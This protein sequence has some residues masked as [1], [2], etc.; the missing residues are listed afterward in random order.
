[1]YLKLFVNAFI[2]F[3]CL[4]A[5]SKPKEHYQM[6]PMYLFFLCHCNS[7]SS[8]A[9]HSYYY[10]FSFKWL[11]YLKSIVVFCFLAF[12]SC[13]YPIILWNHMIHKFKSE[14]INQNLV[15][16]KVINTKQDWLIQKDP[17]YPSQSQKDWMACTCGFPSRNSEDALQNVSMIAI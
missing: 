11:C 6:N 3:F 12:V 16:H 10:Y 5:K 15:C 14:R 4:K 13:Y 7:F 17:K 2:Y 8:L 1:M 9:F